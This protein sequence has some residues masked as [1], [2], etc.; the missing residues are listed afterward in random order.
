MCRRNGRCNSVLP[1]HILKLHTIR[2]W[3]FMGFPSKG[4]LGSPQ[5]GDIIIG[6]LDTGI[7]PESDSSNDEGLSSPPS[8]WKGK[9]QDI[10]SPRDSEGHGTHT[11]STAAGREVAGASYF[12]LAEGTARGGVPGARIA[13]YK[14]CWSSGCYSADILATFDDEIADGVDIISVFLGFSGFRPYFE[15]PVATGS[16]HAMR[17]GILTSCSAGNSIRA[18]PIKRHQSCTL[19]IKCCCQHH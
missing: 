6:L 15:E 18:C 8:K 2:S 9:C 5:E 17:K 16:L 3:D 11:S 13:M 14:V 12:G 4:K 1:N 10:K 7:W 19:D